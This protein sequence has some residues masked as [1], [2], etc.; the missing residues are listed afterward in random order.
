MNRKLLVAAVSAAVVAPVAGYGDG[1]VTWYG[2]VTNTLKINDLSDKPGAEST[3]DHETYG[4]RIGVRASADIGN[5]MTAHGNYEFATNTDSRG[6]NGDGERGGI[7][8]RVGTVGLSGAFGRV[9]LGQQW[10]A[11]F[12]TFGTL[13]SPTYSLGYFIYSSVGGGPARASNT[14]KYSNTFGP[15]YLD[16]DLR[17]NDEA[18]GGHVIYDAPLYTDQTDRLRGNGFGLG[19]S[20][21]INENLTIA[22]AFDSEDGFDDDD[23]VTRVVEQDLDRDLT[24]AG[25]TDSNADRRVAAFTADYE[26]RDVRTADADR[27]G[28]SIKGTFGGYWASLGWQNYQTDDLEAVTI[29]AKDDNGDDNADRGDA[30]EVTATARPGVDV[31]SILLYVGGSFSEKTKWLLGYSTADLN[32]TG[33]DD[34]RQI[35]WNVKHN[36]G[37]GLTMF[38]EASHHD[39]EAFQQDGMMHRL[40][41]RINF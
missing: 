37:G 39:F 34:A 17:H 21:A 41:M 25:L 4:S 9:D 38:Y 1:H 29:A 32:T 14:I 40:G 12:N 3:T 7:D 36:L 22:A 16:L 10:S 20:F 6:N 8:T 2:N 19:L 30:P 35:T 23:R 28:I 27:V 18:E 31:D 15:L 5:G 24:P 26:A 13:V 11:Y 33:V